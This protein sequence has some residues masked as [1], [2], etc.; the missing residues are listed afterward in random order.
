MRNEPSCT[1]LTQ[2]RTHSY[3]VRRDHRA[4]STAG[5]WERQLELALLGAFV[6]LGWSKTGDPA[7]LAWWVDQV[8]PTGTALLR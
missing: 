8:L 1:S 7:E 6:Q 2:Y 4:V 3:G 5:W